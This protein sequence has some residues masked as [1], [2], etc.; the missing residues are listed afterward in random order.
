MFTFTFIPPLLL[1]ALKPRLKTNGKKQ[2]FDLLLQLLCH[3]RK[4]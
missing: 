4:N 2:M 1:I 3:N